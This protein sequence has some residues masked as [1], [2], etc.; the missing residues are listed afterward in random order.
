MPIVQNNPRAFGFI[1][2]R[3][4]TGFTGAFDFHLSPNGD[5]VIQGQ[6]RCGIAG[7][8]SE[9]RRASAPVAK[10]EATGLKWS[11]KDRSACDNVFHELRDWLHL[12]ALECGLGSIT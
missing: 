6:H 2:R 12:F 8:G 9:T 1:T 10:A 11:T 4:G 3:D 5:E 7:C